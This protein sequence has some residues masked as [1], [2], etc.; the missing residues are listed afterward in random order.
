V[1]RLPKIREITKITKKTTNKIFAIPAAAPAIPLKPKKAAI[2]AKT[3][4]A[5]AQ[6]N[7]IAYLL[8]IKFTTFING[9]QSIRFFCHHEP[10]YQKQREN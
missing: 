3:R 6:L 4:K 8:Y 9:Q 1:D 2:N 10:F 7:I 5:I